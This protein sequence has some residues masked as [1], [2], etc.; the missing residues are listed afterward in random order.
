MFLFE[1]V[2]QFFRYLL[3]TEGVRVHLRD[4]PNVFA[5]VLA[6]FLNFIHAFAGM[7]ACKRE[8]NSH[9]EYESNSWMNAFNLYFSVVQNISQMMEALSYDKSGGCYLRF[10]REVRPVLSSLF[11]DEHPTQIPWHDFQLSNE[12]VIAYF[13]SKVSREPVSFH[14]TIHCA[15]AHAVKHFYKMECEKGFTQVCAQ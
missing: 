15:F 5:A 4:E 10:F 11:F 7:D 12:D 2:V 1:S 14:N 6:Y 9:V 8:L 3:G 13:P